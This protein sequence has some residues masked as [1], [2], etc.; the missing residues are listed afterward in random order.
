MTHNPE[1]APIA[2]VPDLPDEEPDAP[3]RF[4]VYAD[5]RNPDLGRA[6]MWGTVILMSVATWLAIVWAVLS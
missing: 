4:R 1:P 3:Q 6:L 2:F 5:Q